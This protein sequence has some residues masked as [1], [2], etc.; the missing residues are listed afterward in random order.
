MNC[1]SALSLCFAV[2]IMMFF[3][4]YSNI[5]V[6]STFIRTSVHYAV[7]HVNIF[8]RANSLIYVVSLIEPDIQRLIIYWILDKSLVYP[9]SNRWLY[10]YVSCAC[11]EVFNTV[12]CPWRSFYFPANAGL[13]ALSRRHTHTLK[14]LLDFTSY[15]QVFTWIFILWINKIQTG[16]K[17]CNTWIP[18]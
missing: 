5:L 8:M 17:K 2:I 18:I 4:E 1:A 3:I 12:D 7:T 15:W 6:I 14:I 9:R 13:Q 11:D 16:F 10:N